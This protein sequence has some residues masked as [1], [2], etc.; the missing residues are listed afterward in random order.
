MAPPRQNPSSPK[1][2]P[3]LPPRNHL[4]LA[5]TG[6]AALFPAVVVLSAEAGTLTSWPAALPAALWMFHFLRRAAESAWL[7]RFG[8]GN[9]RIADASV[10]YLYY[11]GFSAWIALSVSAPGYRLNGF[12]LL[13]AGLMFFLIGEWGNFYSH[14]IMRRLRSGGSKE[15]H[16]PHGFL[17][18]RVSCPHYFFEITAWLG[19]S[20][21]TGVPAAIAFT[22]VGAV[23]LTMWARQRHMAYRETFDG[24]GGRAYYPPGRKIIFPYLY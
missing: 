14:L 1:G 18:E 9:V 13:H 16:V 10:V 11:W 15:K 6:A 2:G 23:I 17:F 21:V 3:S 24:A 4:V 12:P 8:R 5:Y 20:M 19:Y 22:L 7:H